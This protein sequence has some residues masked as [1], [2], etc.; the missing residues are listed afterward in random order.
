MALFDNGDLESFLL[1]IC[2]F[3]ITRK[4]SGTLE[5]V[6]KVQYFRTLVWGEELNQFDLLSSDVVSANPL[7]LKSV[8]LGLVS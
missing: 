8:I 1:L 7:I 5:P 6:V 2:N 4:A 3:N